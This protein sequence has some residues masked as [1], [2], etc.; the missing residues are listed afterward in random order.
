MI[1]I[2][3]LLR[4]CLVAD[5]LSPAR[6]AEEVVGCRLKKLGIIPSKEYLFPDLFTRRLLV[7]REL[8]ESVCAT[9]N[10]EP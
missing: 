6:G 9:L 2:V 1:N 10:L 5:L 7:A 4:N 3:S 8:M